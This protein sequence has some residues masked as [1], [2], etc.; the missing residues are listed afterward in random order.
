MHLK[1]LSTFRQ[2]QARAAAVDAHTYVISGKPNSGY[3][4][5]VTSPPPNPCAAVLRDELGMHLKSLNTFRQPQARAAAVDAHTYVI[6]GKPNSGYFCSVTSP[7]PN[8]V[9]SI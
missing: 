5:S 1:S 7:P 6:S 8:P 9:T 2:P 3:F 4:C